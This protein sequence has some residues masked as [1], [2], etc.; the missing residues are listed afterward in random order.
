MTGAPE[1]DGGQLTDLPTQLEELLDTV[2]WAEK[3]W[4]FDDRLD[5]SHMLEQ[6]RRR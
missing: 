5:L 2:W 3:N 6:G 4:H 1:L